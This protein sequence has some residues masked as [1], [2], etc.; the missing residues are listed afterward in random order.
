MTDKT[1]G[2]VPVKKL[3]LMDGRPRASPP[4]ALGKVGQ[5]LWDRVLSS[6]DISDAG[7]I[8]LLAQAAAAA[9]RAESLRRQ[10]DETGEMVHSRAGMKDNP[11]LKH[12]IAAR[13]FVTRTICRLGLSVEPVRGG[14]GRPATGFG[15]GITDPP[16]KAS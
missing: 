5:D 15:T 10:I 7:G 11:L 9:D 12:E 16:W 3:R 14:V 8:E 4:R 2:D 6:Y 1:A 13:S